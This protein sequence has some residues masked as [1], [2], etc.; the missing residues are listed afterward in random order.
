MNYEQRLETLILLMFRPDMW[1]LLV[2]NTFIIKNAEVSKFYHQRIR[3]QN[4][5]IEKIVQR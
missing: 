3:Q 2:V 5:R 4:I 1:V